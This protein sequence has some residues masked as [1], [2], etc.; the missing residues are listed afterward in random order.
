MADTV[1][2][3]PQTPAPRRRRKH[4]KR[5]QENLLKVGKVLG[6]LLLI[7]VTTGLIMACFAAVYI[8]TAII[9]NADLDLGDI[10]LN[11]SSTMFYTDRQTGERTVYLTINGGQNRVLVDYEKIPENLVNAA[12]CTED[13]RF[14]SHHGVDWIRTARSAISM[15]TGGSI[16]GGSTITQQLIKNVTQYDDVTVKRK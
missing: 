9:P 13:K 6:T 2:R 12:V 5:W 4:R 16:Q 8:Q 7:G 1:N 15:F 3:D 11:L 14:Y 10:S